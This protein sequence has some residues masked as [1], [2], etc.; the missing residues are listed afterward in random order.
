M[1]NMGPTDSKSHDKLEKEVTDYLWR[2]GFWVANLTYHENLIDAQSKALSKRYSPT[3]LYLRTGADGIAVHNENLIEFEWE[4]KT[5]GAMSNAKNMFLEMLPLVFHRRKAELGI[6]CLYAYRNCNLPY[7]IGFW[8]RDMPEI[9]A[10]IIPSRWNEIQKQYFVD[11]AKRHF[12]YIKLD[13]HPSDKDYRGSG[14][15]YIRC[16]YWKV[17]RLPHWTYFID[18]LFDNDESDVWKTVAVRMRG[19][20]RMEF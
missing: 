4:V 15:P 10:I 12:P 5:G 1:G 19:Q 9:D 8:V 2:K 18:N 6:R 3:A 11:I 13:V 20:K 17:K 7:E 16:P 14:D